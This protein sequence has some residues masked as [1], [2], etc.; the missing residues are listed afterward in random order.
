MEINLLNI[1][2]NVTSVTL[3]DKIMIVND[4]YDLIYK[5]NDD[6]EIIALSIVVRDINSNELKIYHLDTYGGLS[7]TK[8]V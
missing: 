6:S 5:E 2:R 8:E 7:E 4:L 3:I 1:V